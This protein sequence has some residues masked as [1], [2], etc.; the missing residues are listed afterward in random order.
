MIIQ[1]AVA[2]M[3]SAA[4]QSAS[5]AAFPTTI[6]TQNFVPLP[7]PEA[8]NPEMAGA[9]ARVRSFEYLIDSTPATSGI[10]QVLAKSKSDLIFLNTCE[11]DPA[12]DRAVADPKGLKVMIGYADIGE[13]MACAEPQL[14]SGSLPSWFGKANPRYPGV[15]TVQYWNPAWQTALFTQIDNVM[16]KGFDGIF[17]DVLTADEDWQAGNSFGNPVYANATPALVTLLQAIREHVDTKYPGKTV[18]LIGNNPEHL[19]LTEPASLKN[20]NG[21]FNEFAFYALGTNAQTAQFRGAELST[22][23]AEKYAP[24]YAGTHVPV[25]GNDYTPLTIPADDLQTL[26][27]YTSLGWIPSITNPVQ[28][29]SIIT[30]GPFMFSATP[31]HTNVSGK[32]G[33]IN[34]LSGGIAPEA[35]LTGADRGDTFVG[36]PGQNTIVGGAGN[37]TIYAHPI[38]AGY[39]KRLVL[40]VSAQNEGSVTAKP[41]V[42]ISVNGG[43]V[44]AATSINATYQTNVQVFTVDL[45]SLSSISSVVVTVSNTDYVSS[46]DFSQVVLH[47]LIYNGV[48]VDLG[49]ATYTHGGDASG[50][51]YSQDGTVTLG[52]SFFEAASPFLANTSDTIDGGGGTNTVVY[53]APS[54][55]YTLSKQANGAWLVTSGTTAEGPDTLTN[56]QNVTFSD[57]TVALTP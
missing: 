37:D 49:S 42:S 30:S 3:V 48:A 39:K 27:F 40:A 23:I 14:F 50:F 41:A 24:V 13:A 54:S 56:I 47:G 16:E 18:Y 25:F 33:Y 35:Q 36:G 7:M 32:I 44:V 17:L 57:K 55:N 21:I 20:L 29:D 26:N 12:L 1:A 19:A 6:T 46:S 11:Q 52:P 22:G 8:P 10:D 43:V 45:S 4:A 31:A 2:L 38:Y 5:A 51:I 34:Y 15:Y 28:T 53:R 9:L